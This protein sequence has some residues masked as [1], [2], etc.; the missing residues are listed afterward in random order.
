MKNAI[1]LQ[2]E[3]FL[4]TEE[5]GK[6]FTPTW[7]F[8]GWLATNHLCIR[9]K[10]IEGYSGKPRHVGK[11]AAKKHLD[12]YLAKTS[13]AEAP[14]SY[15]IVKYYDLTLVTFLDKIGRKC[16]FNMDLLCPA[17]KELKG[18][19][20]ALDVVYSTA[21][22][23][24]VLRFYRSTK[25]VAIVPGFKPDNPVKELK[26]NYPISDFFGIIPTL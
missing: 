10:I 1:R 7:V 5:G 18:Q 26:R 15:Q 6:P 14:A 17:I 11:T 13:L 16:Y 3:K 23:F 19:Y 9:S 20:D 2:Y 8:L 24:F 4:N 22:K 12:A 21:K 25:I